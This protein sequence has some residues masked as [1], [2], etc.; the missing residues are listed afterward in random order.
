MGLDMYLCLKKYRSIGRWDLENN[1][2]L[3][4]DGFYP[5]ELK[6]FQDAIFERKFLTVDESYQV[7]YW[8]K[9]NAIHHWIVENC[10]HGVDECQ[11]IFVSAE[12]LKKLRDVCESVLNDHSVAASILPTAS[13]F[14]FGGREYDEYYFDEVEY[15]KELLDKVIDF[16]EENGRNYTVEYQAS[17]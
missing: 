14:F 11:I 3:S 13:G 2:A 15:T 10:A 4:A 16:L 7:G 9:A 5:P 6:E 1:P 12:N 8:R 17:W